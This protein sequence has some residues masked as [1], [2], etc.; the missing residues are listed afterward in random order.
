LR[1]TKAIAQ[2]HTIILYSYLASNMKKKFC[3]AIAILCCT[4]SSFA[5]TYYV[6]YATGLDTYAGSISQPFKTIT[7]AVSVAVAGDII[8]LRGGVHLYTAKISLSKNG[9]S[10]NRFYLLAYPSDARPILDFSGITTAD[11]GV[12]LSG[13]YWTI[14]G[15]DF[16]KAP[17]NGMHISGAY[18]IVEFCSFYENADTGLQLAN[19]ANN[20]QV[21]NCDSYFNVDASQ[22]NADGFAAK[23]DVGTGNSF[24][25][26]RAWQNSDDGWDGLL[27]T[28]I[29]TNPA[30]TYDSCWCF[31]NGYLK[32]GSASVGNGN[33]FKM[34]GNQEL[35][36]ATLTRCLS[37]FN[38]VKGFDQNNNKGNMTLYNC[39]GYKNNPNFGMNNYDPAA[40][41]V[42]VVKNSVS[43]QGLSSDVFRTVCVRTNNNWQLTPTTLVADFASV[44]SVGLRNPRNA[45]GSLPVINFMKLSATSTLIDKGVDVG[46]A[47]N[48]TAPDVGAFE[49]AY[50]LPVALLAF[51]ATINQKNVV[52][53][54]QTATEQNNK[55]FYIE[56]RVA[57][58]FTA[59]AEVGFVAGSNNSSTTKN[60]S[61]SD[62]NIFAVAGNY[63]YRLR[64]VDNDGKI[65][66]SN[67]LLVKYATKDALS[68][69][70]YP[71]PFYG[72]GYVQF[73]LV[74]KT[75]INIALHTSDGKLV[76]TIAQEIMDAGIHSVAV[77]ATT[78][79]S[80]N[81][82]LKMMAGEKVIATNIIKL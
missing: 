34:G 11:R 74:E 41:K 57:D 72:K 9:T 6:S 36:D 44:D 31:M 13:T 26:C 82:I 1:R 32:S 53:N 55:G 45:D 4:F 23:L 7:K 48:G 75:P 77:Q 21:I 73:T 60:Y 19:G 20:N 50:S 81:Y 39:T 43:F 37:A 14:K 51:A 70:V 76:Q 59:W 64:Q 46:L 22:G 25:G 47:Y 33:G 68:F 12:Q 40:G 66:Y 27:T 17:D 67:V 79:P 5:A 52:L 35:H 28:G 30:T 56:R 24:K 10:A 69:T 2:Q 29:G 58:G 54:W 78:L 8:Y 61:Y 3:L 16:Y 63:Q 42:M 62:V 49:S 38:R 71:N 18:N 80:G 15:I 65:K